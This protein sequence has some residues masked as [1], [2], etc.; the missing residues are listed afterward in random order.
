LILIS[1]HFSAEYL[2]LLL[3]CGEASLFHC[4]KKKLDKKNL[5]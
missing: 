2:H 3:K 1:F 4:K 5:Q